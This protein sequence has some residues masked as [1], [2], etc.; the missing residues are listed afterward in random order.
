MA[1]ARP[2]L[3]LRAPRATR[4]G[5]EDAHGRRPQRRWRRVQ[6]RRARL[7]AVDVEHLRREDRHGRRGV[8]GAHGEHRRGGRRE[9]AG[10]VGVGV[11]LLHFERW[12]EGWWRRMGWLWFVCEN[13]RIGLVNGLT[14]QSRDFF[15]ILDTNVTTPHALLTTLDQPRSGRAMDRFAHRPLPRSGRAHASPVYCLQL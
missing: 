13:P 2:A 1:R 7:P 14:N 4:D 6:S 10:R 8:D 9:H 12:E 3:P 11:D 15:Q 5:H